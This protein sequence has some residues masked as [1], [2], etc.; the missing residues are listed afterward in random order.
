MTYKPTPDHY[1]RNRIGEFQRRL[2][3]AST[4]L[5]TIKAA[6]DA[7]T[8]EGMGHAENLV[9]I[10]AR[11]L[12]TIDADLKGWWEGTTHAIKVENGL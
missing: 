5:D 10:M 1:W 12:G 2:A 3:V 4:H 9:D 8:D 11:D 7:P 6:I